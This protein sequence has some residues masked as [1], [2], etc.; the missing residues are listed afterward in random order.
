MAIPLSVSDLG[1]E[2]IK[3]Q[4]HQEIHLNALQWEKGDYVQHIRLICHTLNILTANI[5]ITMQK[6]T[7]RTSYVPIAYHM[8]LHHHS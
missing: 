3:V 1:M 8:T 6:E 5:I 2:V 4:K 7:C